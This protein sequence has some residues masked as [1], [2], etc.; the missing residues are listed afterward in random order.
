MIKVLM[1]L[2]IERTYLNIIKAIYDK[3]IVNIILN[4]KKTE[5]ISS[6]V[7]DETRVSNFST[8][9]QYSPS[10]GNKMKRR[11]KRNPN[12]KGGIQTILLLY[13]IISSG[14]AYSV[15]ENNVLLH[16][17]ILPQ[18]VMSRFPPQSQLILNQKIAFPCM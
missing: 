18:I 1:K 8:L 9:I 12:R 2:E 5:T 16:S 15:T 4:G 14:I 3:P 6:K 7:R 11:T 13:M 10:K 17:L